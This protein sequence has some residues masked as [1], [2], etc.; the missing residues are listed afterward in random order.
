[1]NF[2][3]SMTTTSPCGRRLVKWKKDEREYEKYIAK[4]YAKKT[5]AQ[6]I[7][8][9]ASHAVP[10]LGSL[11]D[12]PK[13]FTA[14]SRAERLSNLAKE[15]ECPIGKR[16]AC[17]GILAYVMSQKQMAVK[18]A[19]AGAIPYVSNRRLLFRQDQ[20]SLQ[21]IQRNSRPDSRRR[22]RVAG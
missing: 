12:V 19:A 21:E 6:I 15:E 16:E 9:G 1:M 11:L 14:N 5:V 3:G 2:P 22:S 7:S 17:N 10:G 18:H 20:E 8:L 13:I 4:K